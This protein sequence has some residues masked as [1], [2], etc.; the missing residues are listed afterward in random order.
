[1]RSYAIAVVLVYK[2]FVQKST[3]SG[4]GS[5]EREEIKSV[6]SRININVDTK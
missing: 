1:M 2:L 5:G 6:S 4:C 3:E